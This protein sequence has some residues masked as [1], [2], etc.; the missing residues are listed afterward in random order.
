MVPLEMKSRATL[1]IILQNK[2]IK[3]FLFL[4]LI[5]KNGSIL[6]Y[7]IWVYEV[8]DELKANSMGFGE[9]VG[10]QRW[11]GETEKNKEKKQSKCRD[12]AFWMCRGQ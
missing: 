5:E 7:L 9:M 8:S 12:R 2:P 4:L 1:R 6:V 10:E 3:I 11:G